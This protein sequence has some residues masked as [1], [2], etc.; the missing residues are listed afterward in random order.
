MNP[1]GIMSEN[2]IFVGWVIHPVITVRIEFES[3][4][5]EAVID[6]FSWIDPC[7]HFMIS[8]GILD[9]KA[10]IEYLVPLPGIHNHVS[11]GCC[12]ASHLCG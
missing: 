6:L 2:A 8:I 7:N 1:I 9:C 10:D 12:L 3:Q 5:T 4:R 11:R